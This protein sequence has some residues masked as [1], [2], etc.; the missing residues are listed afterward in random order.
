LKLIQTLLYNKDIP[1]LVS[2]TY[3]LGAVF[4]QARKFDV[5][6]FGLPPPVAQKKW[7]MDRF[8]GPN[9]GAWPVAP[10]SL[11]TCSG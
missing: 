1:T 6:E 10:R 7:T 4:A 11:A 3:H 5:E 2:P 9:P 8:L